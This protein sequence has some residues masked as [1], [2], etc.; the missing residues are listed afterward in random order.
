M[1]VRKKTL[2]EIKANGWNL[3]FD[4]ASSVFTCL[5]LK[6]RA[7]FRGTLNFVQNADGKETS[8]GIVTARDG[9]P[10]RLSLVDSHGNVQGYIAII[11]EPNRIELRLVHRLMPLSGILTLAGTM[12]IGS[13]TFACRSYCRPGSPVVQ[14]ASGP[15]DSDLNDA[16]FDAKNDTLVYFAAATVQITH[17]E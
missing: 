5:Q 13:A 14:M 9:I 10:Q 6:T 8:L 2:F 11:V 7:L 12:Q 1:T 16:L 17:V 4:P 15:A 3:A